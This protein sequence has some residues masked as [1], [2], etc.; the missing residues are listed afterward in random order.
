MGFLI[1]SYR[2]HPVSIGQRKTLRPEIGFR[3]NIFN[4]QFRCLPRYVTPSQNPYNLLLFARFV[5]ETWL[6]QPKGK[7]KL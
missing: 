7:F 3:A 6:A 5:V 2:L 4:R 1:G